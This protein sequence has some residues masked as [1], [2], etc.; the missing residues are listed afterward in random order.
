MSGQ[1]T[2]HPFLVNWWMAPIITGNLSEFCCVVGKISTT[3]YR[4]TCAASVE[5]EGKASSPGT[6]EDVRLAGCTKVSANLFSNEVV[7]C[8]L[9]AI[10]SS[11]ILLV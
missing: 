2:G 3:N 6:P 1:L 10:P 5:V 4:L 7:L 8:L 9:A 11:L